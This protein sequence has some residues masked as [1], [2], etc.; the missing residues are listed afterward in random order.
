MTDGDPCLASEPQQGRSPE[1]AT[2]GSSFSEIL[3]QSLLP[4][5]RKGSFSR[6]Q[7]GIIECRSIHL[8]GSTQGNTLARRPQLDAY[9]EHPVA[10]VW[11]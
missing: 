8:H 3:R 5:D 7:T 6:F 9:R 4:V 2:P 1:E 11:L 10:R